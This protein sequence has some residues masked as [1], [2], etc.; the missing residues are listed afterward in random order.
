MAEQLPSKQQVAGS[1]PVS[2]FH[3][4]RQSRL[5]IDPTT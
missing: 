4:H 1:S 3:Q 2:R 5:A